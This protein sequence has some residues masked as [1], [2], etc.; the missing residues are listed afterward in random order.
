MAKARVNGNKKVSKSRGVS[1]PIKSTIQKEVDRQLKVQVE[2]KQVT[3]FKNLV[4]S[5][6]NNFGL[7]AMSIVPLTPYT[8]FCEVPQGNADGE[9]IANRIRTVKAILSVA[10]WPSAFNSLTNPYAIPRELQ[11]FI[12]SRKINGTVRPTNLSGLVDYNDASQGLTGSLQ[13]LCDVK[14]GINTSLYTVHKIVTKKLGYAA[15]PSGAN[16]Y[17]DNNNGFVNNDFSLNHVFSIDITKYFPKEIL[18]NDEALDPTSRMT[19]MYVQIVP[20]DGQPGDDGQDGAQ[21][22]MRT[23]FTYT[24]M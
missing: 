24:D 8:G 1:A 5:S 7:M 19:F 4:L 10:I 2:P 9:R 22:Y 3:D 6:Y 12:L 17:A 13:D 23:D 16:G 20:A 15:W 18:F 14:M 11:L 21:M